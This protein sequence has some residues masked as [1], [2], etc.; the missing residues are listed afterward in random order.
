MLLILL[1]LKVCFLLFSVLFNFYFALLT[2]SQ[3]TVER[4]YNY[5]EFV[6]TTIYVI[7]DDDISGIA[8]EYCRN[9][10]KGTLVILRGPEKI[11]HISDWLLSMDYRK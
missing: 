7:T 6:G 9:R 2:N 5:T 11:H 3:P 1:R 4:N 8:Q 10:F